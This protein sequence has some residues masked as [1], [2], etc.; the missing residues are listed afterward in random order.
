[1]SFLL[2]TLTFLALSSRTT[3]LYMSYR[4]ANLRM[5][6]FIYYSTNIHTEYFNHAAHSPFFFYSK[7][8]LFHNATLL[9]VPVLFTFY[10]Q[11]VLKFKKKNSGAKGLVTGK[12]TLLPMD[13][14]LGGPQSQ[15]QH[16]G[17]QRISCA[18]SVNQILCCTVYSLV[19]VLTGLLQ[20][21]PRITSCPFCG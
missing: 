21:I 10:I 5:L 13:K 16:F 12:I 3:Y 11:D 7:C 9:L 2:H 14:R 4:T 15:F 20:L 19:T 8:R 1:M 18:L 6:H 17:T